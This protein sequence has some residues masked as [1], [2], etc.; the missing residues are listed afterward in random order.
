MRLFRR[1]PVEPPETAS[2]ERIA[3]VVAEARAYPLDDT[4]RRHCVACGPDG[5]FWGD[6][7]AE[8][9]RLDDRISKE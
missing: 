6:V 4:G 3:R 9:V 2:P 5:P 7:A 8:L 1:K